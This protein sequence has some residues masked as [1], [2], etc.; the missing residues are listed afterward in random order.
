MSNHMEE[1]LSEPIH[2]FPWL[3]EYTVEENQRGMRA[4]LELTHRLDSPMGVS[5]AKF[6]PMNDHKYLYHLFEAKKA[7][8]EGR[9][10]LACHELLDVIH[11][12][13]NHQVLYNV[14]EMLGHY[15]EE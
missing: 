5:R 2:N 15:L 1:Y 8:D 3:R 13:H 4:L 10:S 11:F 14:R 12:Y 7:M 9:Y 6:A